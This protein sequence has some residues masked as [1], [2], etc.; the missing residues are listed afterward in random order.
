[1]HHTSRLEISAAAYRQNITFIRSLIG[2][3][4]TISAV[5]K[6]NAYGHGIA[7]LVPIAEKSGVNHFSTFSSDEAREVL[8]S[9]SGKAEVMIMGMLHLEEIPDLIR[10]GIQF[11]VFDLERLEAAIQAAKAVGIQAQIHIEV[12]TGF[13]RTGFDW[14]ER[15]RVL[16]LLRK[17]A[18]FLELK[19]LCTHFAGA[20]SAQNH[21]RIRQQILRF[22]D[23]ADFFRENGLTFERSH[24]AC[25][26][27][28][29][30]FPETQLDLVRIGI[31]GYGFWPTRETF[32]MMKSRLSPDNPNPLRRLLTWK[33]QIMSFKKIG[34]GDF[35][36][37]GKGFEA[38]EEMSLAIIPVGYSHG[39][40]R[41]LSNIG[42]VLIS[43]AFCP[44]VGI[45]NMNAIAVDVSHLA[46]PK[47]GDEVILIGNQGDNEI[48]VGSFAET[49][50]LINYEML[51]RLPSQIPRLIVD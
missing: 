15:Q 23:F 20:E 5:V 13:H 44:V 3:K 49:S 18:P 34:Q 14:E 26:A 2:P 42:K 4:P 17:N 47:Q 33:T 35:V 8:A 10:L 21:P 38:P 48:T 40:G 1:M 39:Y 24:A 16:E 45:V 46:D 22:G 11:Y 27:A 43:G 29:L 41:N 12:E 36:G 7:Q 50:D 37:Y 25:S 30:L 51:T 19:G 28:T 32:Q 31:A 6:G 9:S